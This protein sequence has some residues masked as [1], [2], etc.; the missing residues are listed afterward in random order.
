MFVLE[1]T[2]K[3]G[4]L[5]F[6]IIKSVTINST[7]ETISD[8]MILQLPKYRDLN[9]SDLEEQK[10][11]FKAGYSST[12]IFDEF[13][14]VIKEVSPEQP[15]VIKCEDYFYYLKKDIISKSFRNMWAGDIVRKL[16]E[17]T[18]IEIDD[19]FFK[20]GIFL[21]YKVYRYKSKRF[22]IQDIAKRCGY[23]A[24]MRWKNLVFAEPYADMRKGVPVYKYGQNIISDNMYFQTEADID[25]VIVIS[26]ETDG[27]GRI[28]KGYAGNRNGKKI[29][30]VYLD[31]LNKKAANERAKEIFND[32]SYTGFRG[33][34]TTFG[35]PPT[36]H[37]H[38]IKVIDERFPDKTGYYYTDKVEK[39]FGENG[40]TQRIQLA[41][42]VA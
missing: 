10:I 35:F 19:R 24:F 12:G 40:F 28:Y 25:R 15:F 21:K 13:E 36:Y 42:K 9:R 18:P 41:G 34:F 3:I 16:T 39:S 29:K 32:L 5:S 6:P 30:K 11:S 23:N 17:D 14:G 26:E 22:I 31:N 7:R 37:S 20:K 8:T 38:E 2:L 33:E 4:N 1:H 27:S